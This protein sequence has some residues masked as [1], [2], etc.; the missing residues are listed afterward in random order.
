MVLAHHVV[1]KRFDEGYGHKTDLNGRF[2]E[3]LRELSMGER[4]ISTDPRLSIEE[5]WPEEA[6]GS[7]WWEAEGILCS[8]QFSL[9]I[10]GIYHQPFSE[11][12]IDCYFIY[13]LSVTI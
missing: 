2:F 9:G 6:E 13:T 12:I 7:I 5:K 10:H 4:D 1:W 11:V 8:I 3:F